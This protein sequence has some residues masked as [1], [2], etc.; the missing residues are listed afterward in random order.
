MSALL[1]RQN[2]NGLLHRVPSWGLK[3]TFSLLQSM[4]GNR[5]T[6]VNA[7][8]ICLLASEL[9]EAVIDCPAVKGVEQ[10]ELYCVSRIIDDYDES[11]RA[12]RGISRS[13]EIA[14]STIEQILGFK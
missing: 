14:V 11:T 13:L 2:K 12:H 10:F 8:N 7:P 6:T 5:D 3:S 1:K 9:L 4:T